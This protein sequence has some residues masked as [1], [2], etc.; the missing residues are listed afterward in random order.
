MSG[1]PSQ[2]VS[3]TALVA[4]GIAAL[5]GVAVAGGSVFTGAGTEATTRD[6]LPY[7]ALG[8][9]VVVALAGLAYLAYLKL[10]PDARRPGLVQILGSLFIAAVLGALMGTALTPRSP[11]AADVSPLD[12]SE[13]ER[14]SQSLDLDPD[15][16][17][18]PIDFDGDGDP[19]LD[20]NGDPL[21]AFDEDGDGVID[22]YL[23]PC[24]EP[25]TETVAFDTVGWS[26][27]SA[28]PLDVECDGEIERYL[29]LDPTPFTS[30]SAA[31]P[32]PRE[33]P[34]TISPAERDQRAAD[35]NPASF[36]SI[37]RNALIGLA[38]LAALV[39]L[40]LLW[41]RSRRSDDVNDGDEE[42]TPE[43]PADPDVEQPIAAT[44]DAMERVVDPRRAICEAYGT[45]LAELAAL[46]LPRRPEEGP[47]EHI[48]R[49]LRR[50]DIDEA[51]VTELID[52]FGLA[53]F[54]T[55]PVTEQHRDTAVRCLRRAVPRELVDAGPASAGPWPPPPGR[56]T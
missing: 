18:R 29:E 9:G 37:L 31:A 46:G 44:I 7:A 14:R 2:S 21:L 20:E 26:P 32:I 52:L 22:G 28:A 43:P 48:R 11:T 41:H 42:V 51:S 33:P 17:V 15:T 36:G 53:R 10:S 4:L 39:A 56:P 19:D 40:V 6:A 38:I 50:A 34:T 35:E 8:A 54:S 45:L 30:P 49:C 1:G 47:G 27:A 23:Q 13:I 5:F 3:R 12:D 24:P 16:V 25:V 55:H